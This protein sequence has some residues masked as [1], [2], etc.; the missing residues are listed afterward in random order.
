MSLL[1]ATSRF[2]VA[3]APRND[4]SRVER[5]A[6]G[7]RREEVA[8]GHSEGAYVS[9]AAHM[10]KNTWHYSTSMQSPYE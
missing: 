2:L 4:I 8:N 10:A 9:S 7:M 6:K 3:S 5:I 1:L